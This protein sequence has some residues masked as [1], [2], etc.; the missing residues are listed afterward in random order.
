MMSKEE[1][2]VLIEN[3]QKEKQKT[4]EFIKEREPG[5]LDLVDM[6]HTTTDFILEL[7]QNADDAISKKISVGFT[8][9]RLFFYNDG[10]PFQ[11]VKNDPARQNVSSLCGVGKS[12]KVGKIGFM[13]IGFKSIF[14]VCSKVEIHSGPF[15]F[16]LDAEKKIVP[17]WC[18]PTQQ[19]MKY[20]N[21]KSGK[22]SVF[23]LHLIPSKVD[24]SVSLDKIKSTV[25]RLTP[26]TLLWLNSL[27]EVIIDRDGFKITRPDNPFDSIKAGDEFYKKIESPRQKLPD[28]EKKDLIK[29]R[30]INPKTLNDEPIK[31]EIGISFKVDENGIIIPKKGGMCYAFLPLPDVRMGVNFDVHGDFNVDSHR[32]NI[33]RDVSPLNNWLF[34]QVG[35][36]WARAYEYYKEQA[37]P[38]L[39]LQMLKLILLESESPEDCTKDTCNHP[40][41]IIK[42]SIDLYMTNSKNKVFLAD[43][44]GSMEGCWITLKNSF[45]PEQQEV[46]DL[47]ELG[48]LHKVQSRFARWIALETP[49]KGMK[50]I[51]EKDE[52]KLVN[53]YDLI[54]NEKVLDNVR[55]S[56]NRLTSEWFA[57]LTMALSEVYY[58]DDIIRHYENEYSTKNKIIKEFPLLLSN[59]KTVVRKGD[60]D[61]ILYSKSERKKPHSSSEI[62]NYIHPGIIDYLEAKIEDQKEHEKRTRAL[63]FLIDK[64]IIIEKNAEYYLKNVIVPHFEELKISEWKGIKDDEVDEILLELYSNREMKA[65]LKDIKNKIPLKGNDGK[66]HLPNDLYLPLDYGNEFDAT[67][68]FSRNRSGFVLSKKYNKLLLGKKKQKRRKKGRNKNKIYK[69]FEALGIKT[70]IELVGGNEQ[71]VTKTELQT[72]LNGE[73]PK[74]TSSNGWWEYQGYRLIDYDVPPEIKNELKNIDEYSKEISHKKCLAF[75]SELVRNWPEFESKTKSMYIRFN[76][77]RSGKDKRT[78]ESAKESSWIK[79]LSSTNKWVPV[80][81]PS[82]KDCSVVGLA[83]FPEA[84]LCGVEDSTGLIVSISN[85]LIQNYHNNIVL[86][87]EFYLKQG[88]EAKHSIDFEI[89]KLRSLINSK[90][91]TKQKEKFEEIY[92]AIS[93]LL[94]ETNFQLRKKKIEILD[95]SPWIYTPSSAKKKR[96]KKYRKIAEIFWGEP[97]KDLG[98]WKIDIS[99]YYPSFKYFFTKQ[100]GIGDIKPI[101]YLRF[102]QEV[103]VGKK[104]LN[105]TDMNLLCLCYRKIELAI[106]EENTALIKEIEKNRNDLK[107][108]G[109]GKKWL[110]S[111][112]EIFYLDDEGFYKELK[113]ENIKPNIIY[114]PADINPFPHKYFKIIGVR[115][116][117]TIKM[118]SRVHYDSEVSMDTSWI[119]TG[120]K[121]I[122]PDIKVILRKKDAKLYQKVDAKGIF[123]GLKIIKIIP[124]KNLVTIIDIDLEGSN[125]I[126]KKKK[127]VIIGDDSPLAYIDKMIM[128]N[129]DKVKAEV[130]LELDNLFGNV[131]GHLLY[132]SLLDA[133]G[134]KRDIILETEGVKRSKRK[135]EKQP[136]EENEEPPKIT[137]LVPG[138]KKE[139]VVVGPQKGKGK[140]KGKRKNG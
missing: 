77:C 54:K 137:E 1:A 42:K 134:E 43:G 52:N 84:Y 31:K 91:K 46:M 85:S 65:H 36:A 48:D 104:N 97:K 99:Q 110:T 45:I 94:E 129:E 26:Y 76:P 14:R 138:E 24:Y 56:P 57:K 66:Y 68:F 112:N 61:E 2:F 82:G 71:R 5:L 47:F 121:E 17:D 19:V 83:V 89:A 30:K 33:I 102:M 44:N 6:I 120:I 116:L 107:F 16:I 60:V 34:A 49:E 62:S 136:D 9:Q 70:G 22:G 86:F 88:W 95:S 124:V 63:R 96:K 140:T 64:K 58:S 25:Q 126:K 67:S 78:P 72:W 38:E 37:D 92:H 32:K 131:L 100:I 51:E 13:G 122:L 10:E 80:I 119:K 93:M 98:D 75:F 3:L 18:E 35:K 81:G 127:F 106:Q 115:S 15:H 23:V 40:F 128:V 41:C 108:W 114:I 29:H 111:E 39:A 73:I 59:G 20:L 101:D 90:Q 133:G 50:Y 87:R 113:K 125:P 118:K 79:F 27:E 11:E 55:K 21:E 53:V 109:Y 123:D 117:S 8:P 12:T 103:L 69:F 28:K 130:S 7:V 105:K 74:E 135:T 139:V 4:Y 132:W